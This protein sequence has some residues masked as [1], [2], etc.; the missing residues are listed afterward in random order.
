MSGKP[1]EDYQQPES[2]AP[3]LDYAPKKQT[4]NSIN[5]INNSISAL[6]LVVDS[7]TF[8]TFDYAKIYASFLI[9]H[10]N[11][12]IVKEEYV[13]NKKTQELDY[14]YTCGKRKTVTVVR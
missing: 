6:K 7:Q 1:W 13:K 4:P 14:R 5:N 10:L 8:L 3:W 12:T 11:L 9:G 2:A